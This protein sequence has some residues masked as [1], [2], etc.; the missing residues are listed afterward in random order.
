MGLEPNSRVALVTG[1]SAGVGWGIAELLAA[2]A[3]RLAIVARRGNL[4]ERLAAAGAPR[5]LDAPEE[6]WAV[7]A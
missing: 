5:P 2:E 1:A 4:L 6:R 7:A 3:V